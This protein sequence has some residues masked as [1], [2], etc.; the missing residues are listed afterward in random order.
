MLKNSESIK[1]AKLEKSKGGVDNDSGNKVGNN[2]FCNNEVN[3]NEVAKKNP[4]KSVRV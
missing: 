3:G 1:L 2:K 4:T